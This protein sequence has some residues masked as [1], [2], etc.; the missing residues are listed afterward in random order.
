MSS[1]PA[2]EQRL[3]DLALLRR[4]RDRI[5]REYAQP[6]NVE[7]LAR[8]V[9]MSSGHLSRQFRAGVRRVAVQLSDDAA[10]RAG[11][12]SPTPGRHERHRHL[13]RRRLPVARH[14]QHSL[15]G[16]GRRPTER[17]P[18]AV[19]H[20]DKRH[21][22]LRGEAS[23]QTD[24]ESRS[25]CSGA[26]P[27]VTVMDIKIHQAYLPHDDHEAVPG[28]L[29][30]HPRVR[31]P[32][33]RRVRRAALAHGRPPGPARHRHRPAPARSRPRHHRRGAPHH[34]RD[35]GQGHLRQHQPGH[36]RPRRAPSRR[37]QAGDADVVQEPTDQPWGVRDCAF[38]DPAGNM[39]R[40]SR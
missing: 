33:R 37:L 1:T 6:L 5:D 13:L 31:G 7:A 16:A 27:S 26:P 19:G 25:A 39:I 11:D 40:I 23:H 20:R 15:H 29:P 2:D 24:Q 32:Q 35:D 28:L 17:L 4:V 30:G 14:V 8:D 18:A 9:H 10:H 3:R 38:R 34:L 36:P 12:G 21:A 22:A